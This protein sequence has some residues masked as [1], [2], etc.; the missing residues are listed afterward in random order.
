[1]G[2]ISI[3]QRSEKLGNIGATSM[4]HG[5]TNTDIGT[6]R[7]T[8]ARVFSPTYYAKHSHGGDAAIERGLNA[9]AAVAVKISEREDERQSDALVRR[10]M[11]N[12]DR[13]DRD[14]RPFTPE[15]VGNNPDMKHV[16]GE[17]DAD[18]NYTNPQKRGIR[19]RTG[20]GV[21][22]IVDETDQTYGMV[23]NGIADGMDASESVRRRAHER[24]AGYQ[25]GR[26][27][28][29]LNHQA[30]E[31]RRMELNGATDQ[32][33]SFIAAY[34]NG[35][36]AVVGDI[37]EAREKL[38]ILEG[39]SQEARAADQQTLAVALANDLILE[40]TK[41]CTSKEDFDALADTVK[42]LDKD[43]PA[44]PDAIRSRLPDGKLGGKNEEAVLEEI[45]KAKHSFVL[46][47]NRAEAEFKKQVTA[48]ATEEV[49]KI[50][51]Q[52]VPETDEGQAAYFAA[53]AE[54]YTRLAND[55][56]IRKATPELAKSY[57]K[58]AE[59]L[60]LKNT[61]TKE[62]RREALKAAQ[63]EAYEIAKT[64]F[65]EGGYA[66]A[67][68][69]WY[70]YDS[71][72]MKEQARALFNDGK[73]SKK[74]FGDLMRMQDKQWDAESTQLRDHVHAIARS[75]VPGAV[76][77]HAGN[78]RF[79]FTP[80]TKVRET[81]KTPVEFAVTGKTIFGNPKITTE[82]ATYRQLVDAMNLAL[83]WRKVHKASAADTIKYFDE[84]TKGSVQRQLQD[85][86]DAN[87]EWQRQTINDWRILNGR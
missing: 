52:P 8:V 63:D 68:G 19:L 66:D 16:L 27:D 7:H 59:A 84:L 24:L 46:E 60:R 69:N 13:M 51:S 86:I 48:S 54:A 58:T 61:G 57:A 38:G 85:S 37:F 64:N 35:N 80:S 31:Y 71:F 4:A 50:H 22:T 29:A 41:K 87:L 6:T 43:S 26:V 81:T 53:Q 21:K 12:L 11:D 62:E 23:F 79:T 82:R 40:Q 39:K 30:S 32:L 67:D 72:S 77:Y 78:N 33:N 9:F 18:G 17:Q 14:D 34:K 55:P 5:V 45:R 47:Q 65:E 28:W 42:K 73:I 15:A 74:Q 70:T 1:M 2:V 56:V 49:I 75:L 25:R 20:E 76:A 3:T 10:V 83:D 44:L 36:S